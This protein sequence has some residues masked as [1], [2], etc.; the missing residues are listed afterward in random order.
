M[1]NA[2]VVELLVRRIGYLVPGL[3][4]VGT[5]QSVYAR[6]CNI[7]SH[8]LLLTLVA[9]GISDGPTVLVLGGDRVADLRTCFRVRDR[10][11]RRN[12]RLTSPG[13]DVDLAHAASWHP[14]SEPVIA[15]L[16]Q[17]TA[18]HRIAAARLAARLDRNASVIHCDGRV[19]CARVEQ[20]C[21]DGHFERALLDAVRL[22]GWGEGLTPAGD[23][24]LVGLLAGLDALAKGSAIRAA[25]LTGFRAGLAA[26]AD[27]TTEIAAHYLRLAAGSHFGAD[28]RRLRNALLSSSDVARVG[29]LADDALA[30][31]ATS[32][33]D[34]V[35][36]LLAG[37]SAW[38]SPVSLDE[39]SA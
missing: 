36:G 12:G 38:L 18:N 9:P 27:R 2:P 29:H 35:A 15:D 24:F 28:L 37:I 6:A 21:R 16:A 32:G 22:I 20:A 8:G 31:G 10:V 4:F 34:Q 11:V 17:V 13:A 25:F 26:H 5:V 30:V 19:V 14:D 1:T 7:A 3:S 39:C 33:A 23:D